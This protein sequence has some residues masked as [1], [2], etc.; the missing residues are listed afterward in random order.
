M[1][2]SRGMNVVSRYGGDEFVVLLVE[3]SKAGARLYADRIR[4]VVAK[5]PFSHG[6]RVTASLGVASL[7]DDDVGTAEDLFKLADEALYVA[8]AKGRNRVEVASR[9]N[10]QPSSSNGKTA[11]AKEPE[12]AGARFKTGHAEKLRAR[13]RAPAT[14]ALSAPDSA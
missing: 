2:H 12:A 5:F 3:T 1:K 8:K 7:P 11:P 6:K 13:A 9:H 4:E 14:V 10:W